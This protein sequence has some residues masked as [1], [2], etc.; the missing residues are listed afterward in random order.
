MRPIDPISL[1]RALS[2]A[3][4]PSLAC[5]GAV[6]GDPDDGVVDGDGSPD[7]PRDGG[8]DMVDGGLDM[9]DAAP[10]PPI[11]VCA[12]AEHATIAEAIEAAPPG[13]VLE[14]CA[15]TYP[16]RLVVA[17]AITIR[18]AGAG[19]TIIDAGGGG[20]AIDVSAES[21]GLTLEGVT[22]RNG[23]V[24]RDDEGGGIRC[25]GSQLI[26]RASE[27]LDNRAGHGAGLA[28]R[29]CQVEISGVRMVNNLAR[30]LGGGALLVES[31]GVLQDGVLVNNQANDGGGVYSLEGSVELAGNQFTDNIARES[32]GGIF[33]SSDALIRDNILVGGRAVWGGGGIFV[34]YHAPELRGNEVRGS[35]SVS[36]GGGV[37]IWQGESK[38][39]ENHIH[40]NRSDD[41]G[42]G[43]RVLHGG[44]R[45]ERN[46]IE[47]NVA[48]GQGGGVK[49]SHFPGVFIDNIFRGN[50]AWRGGG[51]ALDNCSSTVRGGVI[52]NNYA[53]VGGGIDAAWFALIGGTIEGVTLR[54][55]EARRGGAIYLEDHF[56]PVTLKGLVIEGN[57]ARVEGGGIYTR[58]THLVLKNSTIAGNR[59]DELGGGVFATY[60]RPWDDDCSCPPVAPISKI[61]FVTLYGNQAGQSGS[62]IWTDAYDVRVGNSILAG[63]AATAVVRM[64]PPPPP[65]EDPDAPPPPPGVVVE[66]PRPATSALSFRYTAFWP[67][68]FSGVSSP[69]GSD[70]N[71]DA[72][73]RLVNPSAG[74]FHLGTGSP[75]RDA[76]DPALKDPDGSRADMGRYG[77]PGA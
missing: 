12:G 64:D 43:V 40:D 17:K 42:A 8:P 63:H 14:V 61:D 21:G 59:A 58:G 53:R 49:I 6:T 55:N 77:G 46:V 27:L 18:G 60:T 26:L 35:H 31:S 1:V 36:D 51:L 29:N 10:M 3:M 34:F 76:G 16:E 28:A 37:S 11:Q 68:S 4:L 2:L 7:R 75:A 67:A 32:G 69:T 33:H 13:A 62:A 23:V 22:L 56:W 50:R 24:G 48:H 25:V 57:H 15:G 74:D 9:A 71:I 47:N 72:D 65:E 30:D 41:D 19:A 20:R 38:L 66:Q 54:N 44:V 5:G 52:E 73:P 45:F 70:G 39:I